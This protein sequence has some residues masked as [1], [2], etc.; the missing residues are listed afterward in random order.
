MTINGTQSV[1]GKD[2][3]DFENLSRA[4]ATSFVQKQA[5]PTAPR[6]EPLAPQ[7]KPNVFQKLRTFAAADWRRWIADYVRHRIGRRHPFPAYAAEDRDR[8]VYP[9]RGDAGSDEEPVRIALAGDWGTGTDEAFRIAEIIK[10]RDPHYTIHLGDVYF[11]GDPAEVNENFL[12]VANPRH[13]YTPCTWPIGANGAFAL[14]GNHEMYARGYGYFDL[15]L[16]A[17]GRKVDGRM[18]GQKA[19]FFCLENRYWRV[20]GLDTGYHSVGV[21]ILEYVF[22]PDCRLPQKLVD[23]L[24]EVV[25]PNEDR[26]GLILLSHHQYCSRFD[27]AY[28]KA[29]EQLAALIDRPVLWFWGHEHRLAI[30][31]KFEA[32]HSVTAFGRCLGHGGMPVDL[33]PAKITDAACEVEFVDRR[34]YPNKEG[35]TIGMNGFAELTLVGNRL[36]VAYVDIGR[37]VVFSEAWVAGN[38]GEIARVAAGRAAWA[39]AVDDGVR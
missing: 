29:A 7:P 20:I 23:W 34:V 9:L 1:G 4:P 3:Q 11:V 22:Q 28:G 16:P 31:E 33:P 14:N 38:D 13:D 5:L 30:Y 27:R 35:L 10:S 26:R 37:T 17:L 6:E 21:P 19:S 32:A 15:M 2:L 24:R 8:G 39:G 12:G 25:R 36:E 18:Q